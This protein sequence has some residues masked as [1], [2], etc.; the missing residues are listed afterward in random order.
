[1][2]REEEKG[3]IYTQATEALKVGKIGILRT[4]TLYGLVGSAGS[5]S[6]VEK[7]YKIKKRNPNK[8]LIIL[9][10]D[11]KCLDDF[12]VRVSESV[13]AKLN[14]LW[15]GPMSIILKI[16]EGM[17]DKLQYLHRGTGELAFRLPN[18]SKLR[19][20]LAKSGPIVAPSANLEGEQ[21]AENIEE[22]RRYFGKNVDFYIDGGQIEDNKPSSLIRIFDDGF[23]EKIR[24]YPRSNA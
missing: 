1:M 22:A 23:E 8:P 13:E 14:T 19:D 24:S 21:P 15:P 20:F 11:I 18:N 5:R 9:I 17:I 7:I 6:A 10:P 16:K 4:D 3:E 2:N 12:G